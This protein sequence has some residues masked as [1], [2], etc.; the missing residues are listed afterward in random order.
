MSQTKRLFH[1]VYPFPPEPGPD[2]PR[3]IRTAVPRD[4]FET[5][6][7]VTGRAFFLATATK[8]YNDDDTLV[9]ASVFTKDQTAPN[10]TRGWN[11]IYN[12]RGGIWELRYFAGTKGTVA[13]MNMSRVRHLAATEVPLTATRKSI[14]KD[15]L[16]RLLFDSFLY[17][18]VNLL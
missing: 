10:G 4:F 18:T 13:L 8:S 5:I 9:T 6:R 12:W 15:E 14:K 16:S 11:L 7:P 3:H 17:L 1:A 2:F